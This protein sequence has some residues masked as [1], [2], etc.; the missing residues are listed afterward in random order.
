[1]VKNIDSQMKRLLYWKLTLMGYSVFRLGYSGLYVKRKK[2]EK[3][4]AYAGNF[5]LKIRQLK[6]IDGSQSRCQYDEKLK[7]NP[8]IGIILLWVRG[9]SCR[10][11]LV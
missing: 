8:I 4:G 10:V 1:M 7:R 2:N 11:Q 3:T 5:Y 9:V 6:A